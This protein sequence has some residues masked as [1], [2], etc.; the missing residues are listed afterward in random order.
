MAEGWIERMRRKWGV[1]P[2]GVLAILLAFSLAGSSVL[3][4]ARP[5]LD[6][7]IPDAPTWVWVLAY[8]LVIFPLYQ[9]LLLAYGTLL[10][11]FGFFWKKEKQLGRLLLRLFPRRPHREEAEA[12]SGR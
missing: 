7:M 3:Y 6:Y 12:E 2:W 1:G 5:I 9:I 8:L 10:G 4:L 11:Q